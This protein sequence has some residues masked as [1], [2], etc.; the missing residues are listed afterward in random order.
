MAMTIGGTSGGH[1]ASI[2]ITPMIDVLLVLLILFLVIQPTLTK[3]IDVQVPAEASPPREGQA[4]DQITLHVRSGAGGPVYTINDIAV[5]PERLEARLRETFA[6]RPR[7]VVFVKGA[8][9]LAY[10]DVVRAMDAA[11]AAGIEVIGLV[12]RSRPAIADVPDGR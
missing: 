10:G 5:A 8:E 3:G 4:P 2:N 6:S 7:K 9:A 12:P 1:Q 11:R